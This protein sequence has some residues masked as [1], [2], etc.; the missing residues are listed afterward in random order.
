MMKTFA[1]G[2]KIKR[3]TVILYILAVALVIIQFYPTCWIVMTS[4]KTQAETQ[5][6]NPFSLPR[7]LNFDNYIEAIET[8]N[9]GVYYANSLI[10]A[11]ATLALLV[12]FCAC[13][14]FAIEKLRFRMSKPVMS[15]FLFG[16]TIPIHVTLIPLFQIYRNM[17]ILNTHIALILPQVGFN[18]AMSIYLFTALYRFI[19]NALLEAAVIEGASIW[20]A[21]L[22]VILPM[23]KNTI[24][25]VCTMNMIFTWN[26]FI[27]ANTFISEPSLKTI[28]IGLYDYVGQKGLVNWGATFSAISLFLFPLLLIYFILNKGIIAGMTA[29]AVKE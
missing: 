13:A 17:G 26:E 16:I 23:S 3:T 4:F 7:T 28:P 12:V 1:A 18:M 8:S 24:M 2:G 21:F 5:T 9:L 25:T 22:K 15:Y 6:G 11:G 19:P 29:G 10:V 27:F 20:E 14:G